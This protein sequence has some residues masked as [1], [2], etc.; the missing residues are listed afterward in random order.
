VGIHQETLRF[1]TS[2]REDVVDITSEVARVVADHP[3]ATLCAVYARGATAAVMIQEGWD[4]NIGVDVLACLAK[5]APHGKWLHDR[6]DSNGA[7]HLKSGIVGP[8]ETIPAEGGKLL[9]S[10][11]QNIFFLEFDGPRPEREAV[12]TLV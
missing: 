11:W 12:V 10:Q 7:A 5:L 1:P 8:S 2:A 9:L 6:I 3:E 4:K